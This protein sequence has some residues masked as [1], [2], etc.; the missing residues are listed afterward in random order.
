MFATSVVVWIAVGSQTVHLGG[1][2]YF[3]L[4]LGTF[5]SFFQGVGLTGLL[6]FQVRLVISNMT[7]IEHVCCNGEQPG[8]HWDTGSTLQNVKEALGE[9]PLLWFLPVALK[10]RYDLS[11][12]GIFFEQ[13][14][15]DWDEEEGGSQTIEGHENE[16]KGSAQQ[17]QSVRLDE[18]T[19]LL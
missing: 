17:G 19:P 15:V 18:N 9:N 4:S 3:M 12:D 11:V 1:F 13:K 2:Q 16:P 10:S 8:C 6:Q 7:N 5:L 14:D